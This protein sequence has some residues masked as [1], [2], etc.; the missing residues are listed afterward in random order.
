MTPPTN[1]A[2]ERL[3][4]LAKAIAT[5]WLNGQ[6]FDQAEVSAF[7]TNTAAALQSSQADKAALVEALR[8]SAEGWAN[9]IELKLIPPQHVL[10]ATILRDEARAA[11]EKATPNGEKP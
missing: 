8:R 7:L 10:S 1:P 9:A 6:N 5:G 4:E 3:S 11:L 2:V